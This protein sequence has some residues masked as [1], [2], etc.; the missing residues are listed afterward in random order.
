MAV[1]FSLDPVHSI[2]PSFLLLLTFYC[3]RCG[4]AGAGLALREV[5]VSRTLSGRAQG[6]RRLALNAGN[7]G[8][9]QMADGTTVDTSGAALENRRMNTGVTYMECAARSSIAL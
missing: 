7:P 4:E 9:P 1:I 8:I 5:H 2:F 6:C 3:N